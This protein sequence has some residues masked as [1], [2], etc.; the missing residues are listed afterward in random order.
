MEFDDEF[1]FSIEPKTRC[2]L[3]YRSSML[4]AFQRNRQGDLLAS[5]NKRV[6]TLV[7]YSTIVFALFFVF[8][9]SGW[10]AFSVS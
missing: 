7:I 10:G 3:I 6:S 5:F 2:E 8:I 4:A 1:Y 9:V